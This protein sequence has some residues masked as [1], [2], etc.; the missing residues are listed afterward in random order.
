MYPIHLP[1]SN[2]PHNLLDLC[3]R[4]LSNRAPIQNKMIENT[5]NLK[6]VLS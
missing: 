1:P 6:I 4:I 3:S 5:E 2:L